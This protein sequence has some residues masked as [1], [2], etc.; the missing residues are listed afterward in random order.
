MLL[1]V[2][3]YALCK[4]GELM[5]SGKIIGKNILDMRLEFEMSQVELAN[6]LHVS[7]SLISAYEKGNR[8]PSL[9]VLESMAALFYVEVDYFLKEHHE[10]EEV[11]QSVDVS[12]L[13]SDQKELIFKMI[14]E[15]KKQNYY[16]RLLMEES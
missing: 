16:E 6:Q 11:S 5:V 7:K 8:K 13:K 14:A 9:D 15:F 10:G 4:E 2:R 12:D 1:F 3:I